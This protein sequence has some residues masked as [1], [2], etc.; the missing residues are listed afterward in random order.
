M[1]L[2]LPT[3]YLQK[4][5]N[6]ICFITRNVFQKITQ[7]VFH[8]HVHVSTLHNLFLNVQSIY[9]V[10][11]SCFCKLRDYFFAAL[12]FSFDSLV[13]LIII[14][15]TNLLLYGRLETSAKFIHNNKS[16]SNMLSHSRCYWLRL[17]LTAL[18]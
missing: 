10:I 16:A 12:L 13:A 17:L 18:F 11:F 1:K 8:V 15:I 3:N 2:N 9:T 4:Y 6:I 7:K 14:P 5:S